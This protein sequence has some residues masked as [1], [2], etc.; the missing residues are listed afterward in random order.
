M[1]R[2]V[3]IYLVKSTA[4]QKRYVGQTVKPLDKRLVQHVYLAKTGHGYALHRAM[5]AH[6]IETFSIH[7]VETCDEADANASGVRRVSKSKPSDTRGAA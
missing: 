7:L 4:T 3:S 6:G 5:R 1:G 2:L